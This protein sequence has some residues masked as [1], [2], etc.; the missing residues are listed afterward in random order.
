M[1][2]LPGRLGTIRGKWEAEGGGGLE[3]AARWQVDALADGRQWRNESPQTLA[4]VDKR[5]WHQ[6][7]AGQD[8][9]AACWGDKRWRQEER[10]RQ[11][12]KRGR[13]HQCNNQIQ[14][15]NAAASRGDRRR[16]RE[17]SRHAGRNERQTWQGG[18]N[19][20]SYLQ[21]YLFESC[22]GLGLEHS[23]EF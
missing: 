7:V 4:S 16:R 11:R 3:T 5:R 20:T 18:S 14:I 23:L 2:W 21:S 10:W 19:P 8:Q 15:L 9:A 12:N 17:E 6:V 13:G 22:I 1:S